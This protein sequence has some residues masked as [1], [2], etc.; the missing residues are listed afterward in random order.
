ML[1]SVS[2]SRILDVLK[3]RYKDGDIYTNIGPVVV[4]INPFQNMKHLTTEAKVREYRGKK[5]FRN[6]THPYAL[7]DDAYTGMI[8]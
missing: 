7:I 4:A 1:E 8:T 5:Y 2:E 6:A 3:N